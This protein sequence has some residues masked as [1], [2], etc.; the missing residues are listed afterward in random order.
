MTSTMAY[1]SCWILQEEEEQQRQGEWSS[2]GTGDEEEQLQVAYETDWIDKRERE[3]ERERDREKFCCANLLCDATS[4][5]Q[6][7]PVPTN[8][9]EVP[10]FCVSSLGGFTE[11][12]SALY[13]L[14]GG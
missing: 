3:R 13:R 9:D 12:E 7:H 6:T 11:C 2:G 1:I 8:Q 4:S 10:T 14:E 5:I